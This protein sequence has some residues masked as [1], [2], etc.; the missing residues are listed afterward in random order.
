M[1]KTLKKYSTIRQVLG[2]LFCIKKDSK[3]LVKLNSENGDSLTD[4]KP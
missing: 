1:W 4:K 3:G 2:F